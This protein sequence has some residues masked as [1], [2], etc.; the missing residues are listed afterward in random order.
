MRLRQDTRRARG[1][2]TG[3]VPLCSLRPRHSPKSTS[4]STRARAAWRSP[5]LPCR[6]SEAQKVL[7]VP[8]AGTRPTPAA[9]A[10]SERPEVR[11]LQWGT[12]PQAVLATA[13]VAIRQMAEAGEGCQST[14]LQRN[15][16]GETPSIAAPSSP[17][18]APGAHPSCSSSP[19]SRSTRT[20]PAR[21]DSQTRQPRRDA[22]QGQK[23]RADRAAA[24][25]PGGRCGALN[26]GSHECHGKGSLPSAVRRNRGPKLHRPESG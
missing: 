9:F 18:P 13:S 6:N 23:L 4:A 10:T 17:S 25:Q 16:P 5:Y 15:G 20:P 22:G 26:A 12:L 14:L 19:S 11:P 7:G 1:W 8:R 2:A 21:T 24:A 3:P